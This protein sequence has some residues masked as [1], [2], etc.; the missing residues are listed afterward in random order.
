MHEILSQK[1]IDPPVLSMHRL[2]FIGGIYQNRPKV[3]QK[4]YATIYES[5]SKKNLVEKDMK[6]LKSSK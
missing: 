5:I 2:D 1:A 4:E 6:R 3:E